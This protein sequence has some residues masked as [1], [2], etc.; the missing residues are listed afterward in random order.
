M[1]G[2]L[3][4]LSSLS[5]LSLFGK[6]SK[7]RE[8]DLIMVNREGVTPKGYK[9]GEKSQQQTRQDLENAHY[10][11]THGGDSSLPNP[12][13][14]PSEKLQECRHHANMFRKLESRVTDTSEGSDPGYSSEASD[15]EKVDL[16]A[17]SRG[18][19]EIGLKSILMN[20][21]NSQNKGKRISFADSEMGPSRTASGAKRNKRT[22]DTNQATNKQPT[23]LSDN[24]R[25]SSFRQGSLLGQQAKL[26]QGNMSV[27]DDRSVIDENKESLSERRS[28]ILEDKE[29]LSKRRSRILED[30]ESLSKRRLRLRKE[31]RVGQEHPLESDKGESL[32]RQGSLLDQ[33]K[34]LEQDRMPVSDPRRTDPEFIKGNGTLFEQ[35][36]TIKQERKVGQKSPLESDKGESL[37]RQGSLLDQQAKL[38]QDS[39]PVSDPMRTNPDF[40]KENGT[41]FEQIDTIKQERRVSANPEGLKQR[42]RSQP[43]DGGSVG[44]TRLDRR[45]FFRD[46]D[47]LVQ[48]ELGQFPGFEQKSL[49]TLAR[50]YRQLRSGIRDTLLD[51]KKRLP[52]LEKV[53]GD[54]IHELIKQ[55][56]A[57]LASNKQF[58]TDIM[59]ANASHSVSESQIGNLRESLKNLRES[60]STGL[61]RLPEKLVL[62]PDK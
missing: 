18:Q 44:D 46:I 61:L 17:P 42:A 41:L 43:N 29:S 24:R 8:G 47:R 26:E 51:F 58:E 32:F 14:P 33:Q 40:V 23:H 36:S 16:T 4:F 2:L 55:T 9:P 27:S 54:H 7:I 45:G 31:R 53:K 1:G 62:P 13:G 3:G 39:M 57:V 5:Q 21:A 20:P 12:P 52:E 37:F 11:F 34:K 22:T 59:V 48:S 35:I 30:K 50:D 15:S 6:R 25:A 49:D 60:L 28:R 56:Y 38:E 10:R 19:G